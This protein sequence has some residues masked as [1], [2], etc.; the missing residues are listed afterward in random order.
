MSGYAVDDNYDTENQEAVLRLIATRSPTCS[1]QAALSLRVSPGASRQ[2]RID[3]IVP[4]ALA[5]KAAGW[6]TAEREQLVAMMCVET[7]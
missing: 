6:T 7:A 1:S 2:A 3:R 4:V 5:D